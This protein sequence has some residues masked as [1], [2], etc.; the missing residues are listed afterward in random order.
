MHRYRLEVWDRTGKTR[1][2][3]F[4]NVLRAERRQVL[5]GEE[6]ITL[7]LPADDPA[8]SALSTG[9]V[10]RLQRI[11]EASAFT[12]WRMAAPAKRRGADGSL[13]LTV[14]ADAL[15]MDLR[16]GKV[17]QTMADGRPLFSFGLVGLAPEQWLADF[18][19]PAYD[20]DATAF[21]L[22]VVE[23]T[24][25]VDLTFERASPLAALRQLEAAAGGE[26]QFRLAPDGSFYYVD[27]L[28]RV[29][30]TQ[31]G[32]EIRYTKNVRGIER[33][34][35]ES[36][37]QTRLYATGAGLLTLA[38]ARWTVGGVSGP[39]G[40]RVIAFDG[41]S[42]VFEDGALVGLW[43][44]IPGKTAYPI[45]A[46]NAEAGTVTVTATGRP[47]LVAGDE[48]WIAT[49]PQ[50]APLSCLE[51]PAGVAEYG[52]R[53]GDLAADDIPDAINLLANGDLSAEDDGLPAAWSKIGEPTVAKTTD[54]VHA[55]QG[56]AAWVV[57]AGEDGA[58][59]ISDPFEIIAPPDR[60][61]IAL[62]V[63][64]TVLTGHVRVELR[65]ENGTTYPVSQRPMSEG[66][67]VYLDL[68]A[69]PV[70]DEPLPAGTATLA[71]VAHGGAAEWVL[72][73]AM[74][75]PV[76][77][78]DVPAFVAGSGAHLLWERA[79]AELAERRQPRVEYRA[80]VMDLYR[81]DPEAFR[82]DELVL[83]D[84][85]KLR[86]P[87]IA[88]ETVRIVELVQDMVRAEATQV[89]LASS[90]RRRVPDPFRPPELPLGGRRPGSGAGAPQHARAE[91]LHVPKQWDPIAKAL[92]L[93]A[94]G[95][96]TTATLE[97]RVRASTDDPWP[98]SPTAVIA[99]RQG[100]FSP[101][102]PVPGESTL[103]YQVLARDGRGVPGE[104]VE[105]VWSVLT[106][107]EGPPGGDGEP[108]TAYWLVTDVAAVKRSQSGNYTPAS[109]KATAMSATGSD[110]P[111]LYAGRFQ[112]AETTDGINWSTKYTSSSDESSHTHTPSAG[113]RA[114]R[115]Q[116]YR[117]GGTALL[118]DETIIPVVEDGPPG[119]PGSSDMLVL[120]TRWR[121]GAGAL[122]L[123]LLVDYGADW[124]SLRIQ[125]TYPSTPGGL[126][127]T[128]V[129]YTVN[130]G[131]GGGH[132]TH[133]I[134]DENG[135]VRFWPAQDPAPNLTITP[136]TG[137][138][139]SGSA[140]TARTV[141]PE[142]PG[143]TGMVGGRVA[144][145]TDPT[146]AVQGDRVIFAAPSGGL[147]F[148][149]TQDASGRPL[150]QIAGKVGAS[151]PEPTDGALIVG[152]PDLSYYT[153]APQ[154]PGQ[155]LLL[156]ANRRPTWAPV[157][158]APHGLTGH[159]D[160]TIAS[161]TNGQ[162]LGHDG[163][164]W[165]NRTFSGGGVGVGTGRTISAG[166]GL[167]GG[168][169]LA[170]NRS[171]SL[172]TG[173]TDGRYVRR[174]AP[175]VQVIAGPIELRGPENEDTDLLRIGDRASGYG[176][177]WRYAG[178]GTGPSNLLELWADNQNSGSP[179]R[180]LAV[181]QSGVITVGGS[182]S[183]FYFTGNG[184]SLGTLLN[185]KVGVGDPITSLSA[186]ALNGLLYGA[187]GTISAVTHS[188]GVLRG[189][190][191]GA[192]TFTDDVSDLKVVTRS[193]SQPPPLE[194]RLWAQT[195]TGVSGA[196]L[197]VGTGSGWSPVTAVPVLEPLLVSGDGIEISP[198]GYDGT[199]VT[200]ITL[201][202]GTGS[203]QVARGNH[204][205]DT[206]Y[207]T[208]SAANSRFLRKDTSDTMAGNF[209]V[210]GTVSATG[211]FFDTSDEALKRDIRPLG[212][213]YD[214]RALLSALEPVAFRWRA[215]GLEDVG[216]IA[217]RVPV[218]FRGPGGKT[219]AYHRITTTLVAGWQLHE[220]EIDALRRE[221]AAL[222]K[223]VRHGVGCVG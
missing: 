111:A 190:P 96:P 187:G 203:G 26:A 110:D 56:G 46:S 48:G 2:A 183:D 143:E 57:E 12:L 39:S 160:V 64:L 85:V 155:V 166:T 140:G 127:D 104:P 210:Q 138:N 10:L 91:V 77:G 41:L 214:P 211:G 42:P 207:Y 197:F 103:Y 219:I 79:A 51:S 199:Q 65:H 62:R 137:T 105:D 49:T 121:P 170:A 161:P 117:A 191:G 98:A 15:W 185:Q 204:N 149:V 94:I 83:G 175:G 194:G 80:D 97:L 3:V 81:A 145:S 154:S 52:V 84:D 73:A 32:A 115:V 47:A 55:K 93:G 153:L 90:A 134:E 19:L 45:T 43:F 163:N 40:A 193:G 164:Q 168:G 71:V 174:S 67:G 202:I 87:D 16:H 133:Q 6:T 101:A 61:Y 29:G 172:D 205:H 99:G 112:I 116:L 130:L 21:E 148:N 222:R 28:S 66:V 35:D 4:G 179:I 75:T 36:D 88:R 189:M 173:Y 218:P 1:L 119:D 23:P 123:V 70:H 108:A 165:V 181:N 169:D 132:L 192:I 206:R 131:V 142:A 20:G 139:G 180:A 212:T 59:L 30:R 13:S 27:L 113:I 50:G 177:W 34:V 128:A 76:V 106:G 25:P 22:G 178:S 126:P 217:Q 58:G 37:I 124:R 152:G 209:T 220:A 171:I 109:I 24:D 221:V 54:P 68:T 208:Q 215:T 102:Q 60:P 69:G 14:E 184:V 147:G 38:D 114:I 89:V 146:S 135:L 44:Y 11:G 53:V 157:P 144:L 120:D 176:F 31:G 223:E 150:V 213:V 196:P 167:T 162:Y 136:Y 198:A 5:Q 182:V 125:Y 63:G 78:S 158:L 118:L 216:H 17:R 151:V 95:N 18:I 159:L 33:R 129:N 107:P 188:T 201:D 86:D 195:G 200:T 72:D 141:T 156:D 100:W 92:T 186:G 7:D 122:S 82:F 8:A 74:V 9:A